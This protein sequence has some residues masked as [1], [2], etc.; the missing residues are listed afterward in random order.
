MVNRMSVQFFMDETT[1][2]RMLYTIWFLHLVSVVSIVVIARK[3]E[4]PPAVTRESPSS[5]DRGMLLSHPLFL[6]TSKSNLS[7]GSGNLSA[8]H[9]N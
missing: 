7:R 2:L 8:A 6:D 9:F 5:G 3:R 4:F 1:K